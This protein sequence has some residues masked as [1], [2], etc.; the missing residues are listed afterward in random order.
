M[1]SHAVAGCI[2]QL[3]KGVAAFC[4]LLLISEIGVDGFVF[5]F[6]VGICKIAMNCVL[7]VY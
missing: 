2:A 1:R 6:I 3:D 7:F 4:I 5:P